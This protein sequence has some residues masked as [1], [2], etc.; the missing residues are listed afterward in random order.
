MN[1]HVLSTNIAV[2]RQWRNR[3]T[4][5]D[6]RPAEKLAVAA[7]GPDYGDGSG[8]AGDVIGDDKHHGGAQKAVYAFAREELDFWWAELGRE[9]GPRG[10]HEGGDLADGES[11]AD[12]AFAPGTFG[13]NLTTVGLD[14]AALK[15][16]QRVRIGAAELEVSVV[17]QPCRTFAG[18]LDERG[19]VKK[20]SARGRCGSYF[21]VAV[22]GRITAGD[23]IHLLGDPDHDV[24]MEVAFRAA[25]G[26]KDAAARVVAA[27]CMPPMYHER[28]VALIDG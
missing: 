25:Q 9:A 27:E 17:R 15:I 8:V 24:T 13:E 19:W 16:N 5:I 26:D 28:M 21:R 12:G 2:P 1:A 18:W 14:L 22:P 4:G 23:A 6:K 10:A 7:P 11:G 20:F 3:T